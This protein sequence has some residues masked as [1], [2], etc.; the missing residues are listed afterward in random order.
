MRFR[1]PLFEG[2]GGDFELPISYNG[3]TGAVVV[4][5]GRFEA[6]LPASGVLVFR[7]IE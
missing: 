5:D 3:T 2:P 4:N 6:K 1:L 7:R